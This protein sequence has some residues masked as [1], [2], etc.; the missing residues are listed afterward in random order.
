MGAVAA[1]RGD[2]VVR[3][4]SPVI[5]HSTAIVKAIAPYQ[6]YSLICLNNAAV[7]PELRLDFLFHFI[8]QRLLLELQVAVTLHLLLLPP[9]ASA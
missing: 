5:T 6:D 4:K 1:E 9:A 2:T 7:S 3:V 8:H